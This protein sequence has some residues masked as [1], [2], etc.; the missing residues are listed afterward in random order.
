MITFCSTEVVPSSAAG[1]ASLSFVSEGSCFRL[2]SPDPS[3]DV[4]LEGVGFVSEDGT[5]PS[6]DPEAKSSEKLSL[7]EF[8]VLS[9]S[10]EP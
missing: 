5:D 1:S 6:V 2:E 10:E 4:S 3:E 9:V 8:F 7:P